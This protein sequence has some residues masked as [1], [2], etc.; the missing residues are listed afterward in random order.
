M[1]LETNYTRL[2]PDM[3]AAVV[4]EPVSGPTL[5]AWNDAL[6]VELGV[7]GWAADEAARAAIFSGSELP[8]ESKPV[9]L[10]YAGHQFGFF[11]PQLGDGRAALLGEVVDRDGVLRD[12]QLK[13][14]GRTP[15]S[16]G[17]DGRSWLGPV[18]REYLVS[19]AMHRLGVPTTRALA[20]V[21]TGDYVYREDRLPGAVFTRVAASHLRVGT[22]EYLAARRQTDALKA[23]A[24]YAIERHYPEARDSDDPY[25]AFFEAVALRQAELVAKWVAVG[26][27]HGVMNTD[28]TS[29]AGETI[30]YGPCAF[31]DEFRRDKVFSSIDH[32]GR[33]AYANQPPIAQWNLARL[34]ECLL[35]LTD[36][37]AALEA[38]LSAFPERY[39]ER[40]RALMRRKLGLAGE[41]PGDAAL[42]DAWLEHLEDRAL[43]YT[44]SF[45]ELATLVKPGGEA[46]FGEV[47]RQWRERAAGRGEAAEEIAAAMNAVNPLFVPRNHRI[48]QAIQAAVKGDMT[49]FR[50][51]ETVLA[52]PFDNHPEL[53]HYADAP[54]P[55]ERVARTFCGT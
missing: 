15:Y 24:D 37:Q 39:N 10:A 31:M 33:Y 3:Y 1:S 51:L 27:I 28:N 2:P 4:P 40:Y 5:I 16:R 44:L 20:A 52:Q 11:V 41:E 8:P 21:A 26:F 14:S 50:E 47:E 25:A 43:D 46:R 53:A 48:E 29:I 7:A 32:H 30:D 13:G 38:T 49:V 12:I 18:V 23:L 55:E 9:A 6:A 17:G 22:F 19:E 42:I 54:E 34:A 35:H 45:R 36:A